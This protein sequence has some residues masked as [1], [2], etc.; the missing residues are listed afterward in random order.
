MGYEEDPDY[1]YLRGLFEA[2]IKENEFTLLK[3]CVRNVFANLFDSVV[4]QYPI[5]IA[6]AIMPNANS[7]ISSPLCQIIELSAFD[8]ASTTISPKYSGNNNSSTTC[9]IVR[10]KIQATINQSLF[11]KNLNNLNTVFYSS[12]IYYIFF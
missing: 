8:V 5:S 2:V 10:A 6:H 12:S 3:I 11:L 7:S 4:E 9:P 1:N